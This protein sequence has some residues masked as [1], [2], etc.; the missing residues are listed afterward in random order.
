MIL[1]YTL[2]NVT[3]FVGLPERMSRGDLLCSILR[4]PGAVSF[5]LPCKPL[6]LHFFA[7]FISSCPNKLPL[8]LHGWILVSLPHSYVMLKKNI[9]CHCAIWLLWFI[10]MEQTSN[11]P[12]VIYRYLVLMSNWN[13]FTMKMSLICKKMNTGCVPFFRNKFPGLTLIDFSR[14]LKFT[15]TPTLPTSQC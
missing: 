9:Q 13:T 3:G 8:A 1:S 10:A 5:F 15:L 4:D 11:R 6:T 2:K 12:F 7:G 14:A